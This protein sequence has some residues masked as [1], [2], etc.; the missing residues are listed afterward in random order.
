[1]NSVQDLTVTA[2]GDNQVDVNIG[3]DG[4]LMVMQCE[5]ECPDVFRVLLGSCNILSSVPA[6]V[7]VVYF[8]HLVNG[9]LFVNPHPIH[10]DGEPGGY[11]FIMYYCFEIVFVVIRS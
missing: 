9:F 6:A 7:Y 4:V 10:V 1:M 5:K 3:V 2:I 8:F 11:V